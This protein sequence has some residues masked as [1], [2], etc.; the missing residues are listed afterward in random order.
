MKEEGKHP[1]EFLSP[2]MHTG[3]ATSRSIREGQHQPGDGQTVKRP[4][5]GAPA[6]KNHALVTW[7]WRPFITILWEPTTFPP[8]SHMWFQS[9]WFAA[10]WGPLQVLRGH[11]KKRSMLQSSSGTL[12]V[13]SNVPLPFWKSLRS[14]W[15]RPQNSRPWQFRQLMKKARL[16][17]SSTCYEPLLL[18]AWL[19]YLNSNTTRFAKRL[20]EKCHDHIMCVKIQGDWKRYG[21]SSRS[22]QIVLRT[23]SNL[24]SGYIV[25]IYQGTDQS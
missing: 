25:K 3:S 19:S 1:F 24:D 2:C 9:F 23:D 21:L 17:C 15:K 7:L 20:L 8:I 4:H 5:L 18:R 22:W 6:R 14:A 12:I 13:F 11:S 16:D 10:C